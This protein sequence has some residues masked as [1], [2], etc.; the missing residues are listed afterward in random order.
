M[1]GYAIIIEGDGDSFSA[2]APELPGCIATGSSI[3][4]VDERMRDAIRLHIELMEMDGDEVPPPT[5]VATCVAEVA[6]TR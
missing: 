3:V 2:Y 1:T 5:T 6:T 4:E